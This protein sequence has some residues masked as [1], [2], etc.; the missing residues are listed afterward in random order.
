MNSTNHFVIDLLLFTFDLVQSTLY[1]T[2]K[3]C[4]LRRAYPLHNG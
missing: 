4:V 3:V 1:C 2:L